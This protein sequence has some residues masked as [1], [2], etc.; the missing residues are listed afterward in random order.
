MGKAGVVL[1]VCGCGELT[2]GSNTVGEEAFVEEWLKLGAG[3]IDCC[4][5]GGGTGADYQN[6]GVRHF[7]CERR[8]AGRGGSVERDSRCKG[9]GDARAKGKWEAAGGGEQGENWRR[10]GGGEMV[11]NWAEITVETLCTEHMR[12]LCQRC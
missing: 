7:G 6:A 2:A 5:V 3:E 10:Y 1:D 9:E 8:V 12:M 11:G 4:S